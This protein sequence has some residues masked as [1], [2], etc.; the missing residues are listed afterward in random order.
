LLGQE[1]GGPG[2]SP[3]AS[4]AR[5][6][7]LAGLPPTYL[8]VGTLD[9]FF[10]EDLEYARRLVRAGVPVELHVYP[11]AFHGYQQAPSSDAA[12]THQRNVVSA[13]RRGLSAV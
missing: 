8:D 10:E 6:E 13:L 9:L 4:P 12:G 5:A 7:T 1:P 2:V 3:Y 11:G